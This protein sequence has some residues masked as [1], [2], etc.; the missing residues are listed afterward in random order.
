MFPTG[1][2]LTIPQMDL[3]VLNDRGPEP[4]GRIRAVV[5]NEEKPR[6]LAAFYE[7][8]K[9]TIAVVADSRMLQNRLVGKSDNAVVAYRL[10]SR[11]GQPVVFDDFYHGLTVRGNPLWLFSR[12]PYGLLA[13][14]VLV[15]AVI[16]GWRAARFLGPPVEQ[17]AKS[18]RTISEYIDAKARLLTKSRAPWRYTLTE[19]RAGLLWRARHD[20]GLPPGNDDEQTIVKL[21]SR[22]DPNAADALREALV[23]L[24]GAIRQPSVG[25][26]ALEPVL[27]KVSLC[28]PRKPVSVGP[29]RAR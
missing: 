23:A 29:Q 27:Q 6:T 9:G 24:D 14:A 8:G 1:V 13:I 3:Q 17:P 12:F 19:I 2:D 21:L 20:L 11:D 15:A 28:V 7:S 25:A 18:R 22:R 4:Q 10:L 5:F 16:V 26:S